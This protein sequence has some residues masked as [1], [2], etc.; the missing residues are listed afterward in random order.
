MLP[1]I[2]KHY[3]PYSIGNVH[4]LRFVYEDENYWYFENKVKY[5]KS[6]EFNWHERDLVTMSEN[7]KSNFIKLEY[8]EHSDEAKKLASAFNVSELVKLYNECPI[9]EYLKKITYQAAIN[10]HFDFPDKV[11]E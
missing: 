11:N 1:I 3:S 7:E 8:D 4:I 2:G 10:I 6:E 5:P 9:D